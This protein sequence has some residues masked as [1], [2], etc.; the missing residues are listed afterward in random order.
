M[1]NTKYTLSWNTKLGV[2]SSNG[3]NTHSNHLEPPL[4]TIPIYFCKNGTIIGTETI[5]QII[6]AQ[7]SSCP[8]V[9]QAN[10]GIPYL[11]K[12][13]V[14][15]VDCIIYIFNHKRNNNKV[16][17]QIIIVWYIYDENELLNSSWYFREVHLNNFIISLSLSS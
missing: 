12:I 8:F 4:S 17:L 3:S 10:E 15:S 1:Y 9:H 16:M 6:S 5:S 13:L 11:P 2:D 14:C 7:L